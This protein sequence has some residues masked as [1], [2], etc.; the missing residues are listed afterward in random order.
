MYF[1]KRNVGEELNPRPT[2]KTFLFCSSFTKKK[3]ALCTLRLRRK[4]FKLYY[5]SRRIRVIF[6]TAS[7]YRYESGYKGDPSMKQ[8]QSYQN[9]GYYSIFL[10]F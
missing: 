10:L 7:G 4:G 3:S 5:I 8:S 9:S 1:E 2:K 6:E